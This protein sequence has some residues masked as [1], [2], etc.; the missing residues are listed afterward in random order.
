MDAAVGWLSLRIGRR[1]SNLREWK[2]REAREVH[3]VSRYFGRLDGQHT[4]GSVMRFLAQGEGMLQVK[5][6]QAES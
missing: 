5:S 3:G 2:P 6:D 4:S 1:L